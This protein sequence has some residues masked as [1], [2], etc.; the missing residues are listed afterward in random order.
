VVSDAL[1]RPWLER[2][3]EEI[4]GMEPFDVHTHIGQNDPDGYRCTSEQLIDALE[5]VD[6]RGVVFP[7]H[8]PSGYPAANDRVMGEAGES[9]GRLT[10]FARL[11]PAAEP[12]GEAER[13]LDAGAAGLKLHPRAEGFT[14]DHPALVDVFALADERRIPII[15]HAGRGIPALG[16]H[17]VRLCERFPGARLILAHAGIC[18]LAWIW[19]SAAEHPNLYFDTAWWSPADLL[20]LFALVPPGQI[21]FG[22]DAPYGT[23]SLGLTLGI[24]YAL[25]AGLSPDQVRGFTGG[26]L[27]R[28]IAREDPLDLGPPPGESRVAPDPI[29][30]RVYGYLL[31]AIG[32]MMTGVQPEEVLGLAALACEVGDDAPQA[33]VCRSVLALLEEQREYAAAGHDDGRPR[34][35]TPGIH[36]V[37]VAAGVARTPDVPLPPD[38]V[39]VDVAERTPNA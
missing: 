18:D 3:R 39:P 11:D 21:L 31:N 12:A 14:L 27:D 6:G 38:P 23:P 22:S 2:L 29:L 13:C 37:V 4:P 33:V 19:R 1:I 30:D 5:L 15:C 26:Q 8:E 17:A 10:P 7:M 34:R 20:A 28:L 32:Q 24:R 36:L 25:Q 16:R 9:G 35:F